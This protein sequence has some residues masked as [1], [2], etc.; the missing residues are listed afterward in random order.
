MIGKVKAI[1]MNELETVP[2]K[3]ERNLF[4]EDESSL[5]QKI[6]PLFNEVFLSKTK[7]LY[8]QNRNKLRKVVKKVSCSILGE[9]KS[10]EKMII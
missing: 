10:V 1:P 3:S 9:K 2:E 6:T 8:G 4:V 7:H 5:L